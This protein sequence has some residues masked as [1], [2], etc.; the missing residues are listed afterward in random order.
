MKRAPKHLSKSSKEFFNSIMNAYEL[1][2]HHIKILTLACEC[3]DRAKNAQIQIEKGG[4]FILDRYKKPTISPA[5]RVKEQA[6]ITFA[7]LIRELGLDLE[8]PR[9]PGRPPGLY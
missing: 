1:E 3:L 7:R 2:E 8:P 5:V 6:E 9:E 4:L